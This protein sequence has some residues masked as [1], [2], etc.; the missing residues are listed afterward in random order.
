MNTENVVNRNDKVPY[1]T[2]SASTADNKNIIYVEF[3]TILHSIMKL[4]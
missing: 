4:K 1:A 2:A 3:V